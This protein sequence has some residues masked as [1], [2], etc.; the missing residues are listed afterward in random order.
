MNKP[1]YLDYNATT[2]I[3]PAVA[4]T[5]MPFIKTHFGN[6]SSSHL[7]G[8]EAKRA[9][10]KARKQVAG[11]LGCGVDEIIFT[12]GGSESN[13]YAIRGTA[14]A[15]RNKGNH[16]ITSS[17]E[18]PAV[19]EVCSF[20]ERNG[21]NVTYLPVDEYGMVD[22]Q[23]V[24]DSITPQTILITI[25]HANN[26]VG[27]IQP[28]SEIGKIAR[29]H[30][31]IFHSD[32]AQSVGKVPVNVN[33]MN[34]DLLSIAG[35]KFYAPKGIGALYI[36]SGVKLEKLIYGA[37]HEMNLRAGTENVIEIVGLGEACRIVSE[38]LNLFHDHLKKMRD[39]LETGLKGN[40]FGLRINGHPEKRLANTLSISF[41]NLE[42]NT[43]VSELV[44]VA[45]SAGAACHSDSIDISTTLKAMKVPKEDAMGTIRLSTGRYTTSEEI[46]FAVEEISSLV[47][48]LQPRET[49]ISI[50]EKEKI[51]L[52]RYTHGLG[53]ACKLRPQL[54]EEV[55]KNIPIPLDK[56]ILV[57]ANTSDDAAVYKLDDKT[58]IVQ[59]VDFFTPIVDDPFDFGAIAASNSL[60]DIYAMGGKPLFALNVVGFPSN[61]L[62]MKVLEE[63]LKGA[64]H[65]AEKAGIHII[66][67]H[68]VDDIEPKFGWSV[69]GIIHPDKVIKNNSA[70]PGDVLILTKPI[71]TGI[72]STA[73]KQNLLDEETISELKSTM[74]EL[75]KDAAEAMI[76]I[77]VNSCTDITGFGLLG[78]LL[79]M[80]NAS[81]TS[82]V[83]E[84]E[85]VPMLNNV[86]EF[87]S[88][89]IIPGG[90]K[91]NYEHTIKHVKYSNDISEIKR[92]VLNDAQTS[93]GLLI[94]VPKSKYKSLLKSLQEREVSEAIV[95]GDVVEFESHRIIVKK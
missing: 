47:E 16:I 41:R 31:I 5:M 27:T 19:S 42:A 2:P 40:F 12:S 83:I 50:N 59:T 44:D 56:N 85:K 74:I 73:L 95:I 79:E 9:V 28:I 81:N 26:E 54:L 66:G 72:L 10:E 84:L 37:D 32:C 8:I 45:V 57:G 87:A 69:T 11:M 25:M 60:S 24:I 94:S 77:G 48:R 30:E 7:F 90:T 22:P 18:H 80:M 15:N 67:G 21:F 89:G 4:E 82:A 36:R 6:P 38:K 53:C 20:L 51:K 23:S 68:T 1:V 46:D 75:N 78:H 52:T 62:P 34:V 29:E 58:A 14:F 70:K 71:G 13:N 3:D 88:S 55:L 92:L 93:G 76:E 61:R 35:H 65:I 91:S 49:I 64:Q 43:I 86:L 17:I 39:R 63:I 33:E